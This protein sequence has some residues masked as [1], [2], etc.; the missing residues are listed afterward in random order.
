LASR[1]SYMVYASMPDD[2]LFAAAQSGG[3]VEPA[4]LQAQLTRMLADSKSIFAQNFSEQW[5]GV[6]TVDT[7]QPDATLFP[8]FNAELGQSMKRE[9]DLFFDEFVR[10]DLPLEN[11]LTANFTYIDNRL[12]AHYG[13]P[14]VGP[15]MKRVDLTT[16]QRGGLLSMGA[17]MTATSRG[18]RTSPVARGRWTL[19]ELLCQDP[20]APP[21]DVSIPSDAVI[22]A[23]TE[24]AFLT[25]HRQNP[26]CAACH[27]QMDPIGLALENYDAIGAWRSMDHGEVIDASGSLPNGATFN[28]PRELAQ[29]VAKDPRFRP[30]FAGA[31]LTYALGRSMR[32]SDTPY[33]SALSQAN[34]TGIGLREILARIVTSDP[35]RQRRGEAVAAGGN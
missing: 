22:T 18:N 13:L 7:V 19:S 31:V 30:C 11:L 14:S 2:A 24:R 10:T 34:A 15:D 29:V 6:R 8:A 25:A 20:P 16:A 3:L 23:T 9:V 32:G 21:P 12:A 17:L 28:G 5:L 35:F 27:N 26:T 4:E 33:L 1:L